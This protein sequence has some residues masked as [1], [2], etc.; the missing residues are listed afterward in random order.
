MKDDIE[1][2]NLYLTKAAIYLDAAAGCVRETQ[3]EP[4]RDNIRKIAHALAYIFDLQDA[5]YKMSP[6]LRP[7]WLDSDAESV[8][9]GDI[10][11]VLL[12][13]DA[14]ADEGELHPA[15]A[16]IE[17]RLLQGIPESQKQ[18]LLSEIKRLRGGIGT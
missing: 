10:D 6:E 13:A 2:A 17:K 15:I 18:L 1:K 7:E 9:P 8:S 3:L 14:L 5:V 16:L 11:Q 12:N 4:V